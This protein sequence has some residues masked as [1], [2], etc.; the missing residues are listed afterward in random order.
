M[1]AAPTGEFFDAGWPD[2]RIS[3]R[4]SRA[5]F[6]DLARQSMDRFFQMK[7][8]RAFEF[9]SG[10]LRLVAEPPDAQGTAR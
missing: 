8:L 2:L 1:V 4:D 7:G 5:K 6:T 9:A 3:A 10:G